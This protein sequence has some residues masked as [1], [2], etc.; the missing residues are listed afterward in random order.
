M[1]LASIPK[2]FT[3][4]GYRTR[5]TLFQTPGAIVPF[6][7]G[8]HYTRNNPDNSTWHDNNP[9]KPRRHRYSGAKQRGTYCETPYDYYV[10]DGVHLSSTPHPAKKSARSCNS[11]SLSRSFLRRNSSALSSAILSP[12]SDSTRMMNH[13]T[14]MIMNSSIS[15]NPPI[16][17]PAN[18]L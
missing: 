3:F 2:I 11:R 7:A 17:E 14:N 15:V 18:E 9:Q 5:N 16:N 6:K 12:S 4:S 8:K 10:V 13:A 1:I